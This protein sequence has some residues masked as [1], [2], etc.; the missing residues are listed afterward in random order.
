MAYTCPRIRL[1]ILYILSFSTVCLT[2]SLATF[3]DEKCQA[4][5]EGIN[6]PNG[7]PNG[8]CT[9]LDFKGHNWKSFQIVGLDSGCA[10]KLRVYHKP[11]SPR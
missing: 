4:S 8:T 3:K 6:G 7:Y 11:P 10:G 9:P 2:S 1:I 5:L